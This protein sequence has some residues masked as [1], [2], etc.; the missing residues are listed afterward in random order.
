MRQPRRHEVPSKACPM[1][2]W[3]M[4]RT[5]CK[6]S[7]CIENMPYSWLYNRRILDFCSIFACITMSYYHLEWWDLST[8]LQ[9]DRQR[10]AN[11]PLSS[12]WLWE[13]V[14]E[15]E[16]DNWDPLPT[17]KLRRQTPDVPCPRGTRAYQLAVNDTEKTFI[18]AIVQRPSGPSRCMPIATHRTSRQRPSSPESTEEPDSRRK[19]HGTHD[20]PGDELRRTKDSAEQLHRT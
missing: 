7:P 17:V 5:I 11:H 15:P 19:G 2:C 14:C 6:P 16:G 12:V 9:K 13:L 10:R 4:E 8:L 3:R 1:R 18:I 20:P